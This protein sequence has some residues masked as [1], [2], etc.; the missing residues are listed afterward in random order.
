MNW[1]CINGEHVPA[2]EARI[3]ADDRGLLLGDGLFET[4]RSFQGRLF[5]ERDHLERLFA[6][7]RELRL[8]LPW[9]ADDLSSMMAE[10]LELNRLAEARVRL[11]VTRGRHRGSM[12][13]SPAS[14]PS[15]LISA[16]PIPERFLDPAPRGLSLATV[17][18][19][20]S[21]HNPI[22]RHKTL[23][24]LPHLAARSEAEERGADEALILDERGNA[25]SCS[26]GTLFALHHDQLFTP[27]LTGPVLPGV[28]RKAVLELA[29]QEGVPVREDF[30]SPIMLAG[31][32]EAFMT[33]SVQEIAPVVK[34]DGRPV[35]SGRPGAVTSRLLRAYRDLRSG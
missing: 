5:R 18:I 29:R 2:G 24:R 13:L 28:T 27:P 14:E 8:S 11:T 17:G 33:N 35:G 22:F 30:F 23:N 4:M 31:A 16:E 26:T 12:G 9:S 25:A 1:V 6:S 7:A 32:E 34:V 15:L 19:R 21:E 10:L 3:R 20:F